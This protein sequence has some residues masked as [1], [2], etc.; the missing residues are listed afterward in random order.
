MSPYQEV[1]KALYGFI[2]FYKLSILRPDGSPDPATPDKY[3]H[4]RQPVVSLALM[5]IVYI[6]TYVQCKLS[7][8]MKM[9]SDAWSLNRGSY[10]PGYGQAQDWTLKSGNNLNWGNLKEISNSLL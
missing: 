1:K 8:L 4:I 6:Y 10:C 9:A 3:I 5:K 2:K 7:M